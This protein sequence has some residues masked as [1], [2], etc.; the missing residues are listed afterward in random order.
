MNLRLVSHSGK[1]LD[2]FKA[3]RLAERKRFQSIRSLSLRRRRVCRASFPQDSPNSI[4][5]A[6]GFSVRMRIFS[7]SADRRGFQIDKWQCKSK[8]GEKSKYR[9]DGFDH[10][11]KEYKRLRDLLRDPAS[12]Q[13]DG[14]S[15]SLAIAAV[16]NGSPIED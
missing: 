3:F 16:R 14:R 10:S 9:T 5:C 15:S 8:G 1:S 13:S 2:T 6:L 7:T 12:V 4:K 11:V